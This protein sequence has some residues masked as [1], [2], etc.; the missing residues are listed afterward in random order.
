MDDDDDDDDE[1]MPFSHGSRLDRFAKPSTSGL[2]HEEKEGGR[3]G[4]ERR[5]PFA[6]KYKAEINSGG[7]K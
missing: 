3:G 6:A 2:F 4:E 7:G 5:V 1:P